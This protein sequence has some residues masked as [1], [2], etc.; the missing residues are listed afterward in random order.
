MSYQIIKAERRS[1]H[2]GGT[3]TELDLPLLEQKL[4]DIAAEYVD[5]NLDIGMIML[6]CTTF[7]TFAAAI[8]Q[9]LRLPVVDYIG[10]I[11]FVFKSVVCKACSGFGQES[12]GLR[13]S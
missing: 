4:V 2:L 11:D 12:A 5:N 10:F 13:E 8:Q 6:E 7:A 9:H 3:R 1:P